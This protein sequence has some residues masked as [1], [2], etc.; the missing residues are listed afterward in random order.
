MA[1]KLSERAK[2]AAG[3]PAVQEQGG[4]VEAYNPPSFLDEY[5]ERDAGEGVSTS[6]A[7]NLVPLVYFLQ[8]NSP[9]VNRR[10]EKYVP[11]AEPGDIWLKGAPT[12]SEIVKGEDGLIFQ[13]CFFY[14][15]VGEWVPRG[16]GGQGGGGFVAEHRGTSLTFDCRDVPGAQLLPLD[17]K[18][19]KPSQYAW[20]DASGEHDLVLA[21]NY[22]GR[23]W[24]GGRW[25]SYLLP[26][27]KTK[28]QAA[29]RMMNYIN[30]NFINPTTAE[31]ARITRE[32]FP[33]QYEALIDAWKARMEKLNKATVYPSYSKVYR[34][35][36]KGAT[37]AAGDKYFVPE[38]ESLPGRDGWVDKMA[39]QAGKMLYSQFKTGELRGEAPVEDT[40]NDG[41]GGGQANDRA[42]EAI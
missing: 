7:D 3:L 10:E 9:Q 37:N 32:D 31:G 15:S 23:V 41:G 40:A 17:R 28:V 2:E 22:A 30:L 19:G 39:Y 12:G 35:I 13:P 5:A 38:V 14:R 29:K 34:I 24:I 8:T 27:S 21:L 18:T 1:A 42:R 33:D 25:L 26:L 16:E 11:G 4:A 6:A 20:A 36:T